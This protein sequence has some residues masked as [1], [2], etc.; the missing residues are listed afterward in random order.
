[1]RGSEVKMEFVVIIEKSGDGTCFAFLPDLPGC[2]ACGDTLD[3]MRTLIREA[4]TLHLESLREHNEP[5]PAPTSIV[6]R[7]HAA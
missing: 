3:E 6:D 1:V 4:V 5:V 7:V 2:V